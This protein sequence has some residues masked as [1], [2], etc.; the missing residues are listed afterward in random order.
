MFEFA[1]E[2]DMPKPLLYSAL[3][4]TMQAPTAGERD[5]I[6]I[7]ANNA[8]LIWQFVSGFNWAGFYR[9]VG[10]ELVVPVSARLAC[11]R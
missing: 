5:P 2:P 1:P 6:A 10:D 7:M 4:R 3:A 8:A 11:S 9:A